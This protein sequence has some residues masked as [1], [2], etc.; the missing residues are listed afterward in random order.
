MSDQANC[1][2]KAVRPGEGDAP[3]VEHIDAVWHIRSTSAVRQILR[4]KDATTQ[5]GFNSEAIPEGAMR[6]S[7]ILFMDGDAHRLQRSKIARFFAPKTVSRRYRQ[8]M[9]ERAQALVAEIATTGTARLDV[10]SL[11][12]ST[13]VAAEVI[14]LTHTPIPGLSRRLERLLKQPR[15]DPATQGPRQGVARV[16][17]TLRGNLPMLWFYLRDVR[18]AIRANRR[19]PGENVISHLLAEGYSDPEILI[20]CVTYG[21]AGMATTREFISMAIWHLLENEPLRTRYLL[22]DEPERHAIL[23]EILRLEPIVGHLYRRARSEITFSDAGQPYTVAPGELLDLYIR[24]SNA[25]PDIVGQEPLNLCPARPMPRGF[26]PE[27]MI[28]GDGAHKCPGNSLAIQES[29]ILLRPL[30]ALNPTLVASP[31][32]GWSDITAG[33]ELRDVVL[34]VPAKG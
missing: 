25:D 32:L 33:Y 2:R 1:Q 17:G 9:D 4:E 22:A 28:F 19:A 29:D 26:G 13:A 20:E 12:Y 3:R 27:V 16:L 8:L 15:H 14:G 5:A 24:Q 31:T 23:A 34:S 18:P 11:R 30:L 10:V 7:P 6:H 21:A